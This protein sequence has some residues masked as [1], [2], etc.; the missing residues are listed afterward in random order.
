MCMYFCTFC[1]VGLLAMMCSLSAAALVLAVHPHPILYCHLLHKGNGLSKHIDT[2]LLAVV[3][4]TLMRS[5]HFF[6]SASFFQERLHQESCR[7]ESFPRR[8][9]K[10]FIV[11]PSADRLTHLMSRCV[12]SIVLTIYL[13]V[14]QCV[15]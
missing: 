14:L 13:C 1:S 9:N 11:T 2:T 3:D 5:H 7:L 15:M 12:F 10:Q 6:P 8:P 4:I